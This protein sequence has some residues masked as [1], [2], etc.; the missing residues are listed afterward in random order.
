MI[1]GCVTCNKELRF[2]TCA[3]DPL[4]TL[5]DEVEDDFGGA[6]QFVRFRDVANLARFAREVLALRGNAQKAADSDCEDSA[7][8]VVWAIDGCIARAP[9][10]DTRGEADAEDKVADCIIVGAMLG[11]TPEQVDEMIEKAEDRPAS[12][13]ECQCIPGDGKPVAWCP[14]HGRGTVSG[15][16][17][18]LAAYNRYHAEIRKHVA[19]VELM[20]L[21]RE[22]AI[23][24]RDEVR[25][26]LTRT[27]AALDA[28]AREVMTDHAPKVGLYGSW[29]RLRAALDAVGPAPGGRRRK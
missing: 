6:R 23:R 3:P 26:E 11:H 4:A 5:L 7:Q 21:D 25:Y 16:E 22:E 14:V 9:P 28:V 18:P 20:R 8:G 17:E 24:Q 1:E 2:C 12:G 15:V 13:G 29:E 10:P 27:Q 19:L